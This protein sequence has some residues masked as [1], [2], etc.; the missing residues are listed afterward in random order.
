MMNSLCVFI[1]LTLVNKNN[2][3]VIKS[4]ITI[5]IFVLL[6]LMYHITDCRKNLKMNFYQKLMNFSSIK[7]HE[8]NGIAVCMTT[9]ILLKYSSL[10]VLILFLFYQ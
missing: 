6:N 1:K 3:G 4:L 5:Q 9:L 8:I 10:N 2:C 7:V